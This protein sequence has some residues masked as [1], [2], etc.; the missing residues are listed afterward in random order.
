[1]SLMIEVPAELEAQLNAVAARRGVA[2][3]E[4]LSEAIRAH[5][6]RAC[7]DAEP[8]A[9]ESSLLEQINQQGLPSDEWD[10]YYQLVE[11]RRDEAISPPELAELLATSSRI[12]SMSVHRLDLLRELA[13]VRRTTVEQ[14]MA[15]LGIGQSA[16]L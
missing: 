14:L 2:P 15:D 11:K 6:Q 4:Y 1:M 12:E 5:L 16:V 9:E 8:L 3:S 13:K 7:D 10:R